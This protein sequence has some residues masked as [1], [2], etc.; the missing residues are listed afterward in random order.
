MKILRD[1]DR[2][3]DG[4]K[5]IHM[6]GIGGSGM[7]PLAE[8][9]HSKGYILSGSDN[10]ESDPL[11]RVRKLGATVYM[12]HNA[13]NIKGAE[14]VV[15]SA[16]ISADNPEL[17]AAREQGIPTMERSHLL[18]ALTRRY[19]N[20]IGVCGTHGK[21]SVTSMITQILILNKMEPTAVIGGKLP[22]INSN[23][24]TGES[25]TMVC[26]ACEFV[27]TFLQM[28]PDIAVLLNIDNDHLDYF[29]TMDN[30]VLSFN[31]FLRMTK[32]SYVNGDDEL[33]LK[34]TEGIDADIVTFGFGENN[35]YSARNIQSGKY[36]FSFDVFKDGKKLINISM[37]IPG[38]HNVLNGLAAFGVCYDMGVSAQG[39]KDAIEKFTGAGRRFE[40]LGE[41]GGFVLADDYA[42][43]PTEIK[44]TLSAA[45]HLDYNRVIA[46]FQPFTFSRTALL[47]DEFIEALSIADKVVLTP[48][49]GSREVNTYGI[50][51]EDIAVKLPDAVI[52][53]GF[54]NI[55]DKV[56]EIADKG[57][58]VI[59]MG[60][61]D[62][63]KAAHKIIERLG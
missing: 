63:Y 44:A 59:T 20:V 18:G 48:I 13:E 29:K 35:T 51:S 30:L 5:H 54:E 10:N 16:A 1:E 53:D 2:L 52:V 22:L 33:A 46:V 8:I 49:M 57:D 42:H 36:G 7:C 50:K 47:K 3:I 6:I 31:K 39:I 14:L 23:G 43:H 28:S 27:D 9:L 4:I 55:A 19:D 34:A 37:H 11:K 24:I 56:I 61:G 12:G 26:E 60:G 21:T 41:Y 17:K 15:Y 32:L 45:K 38:H 25:Q 62:I 58:L 40:F